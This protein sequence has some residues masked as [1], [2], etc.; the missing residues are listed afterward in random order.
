MTFNIK[1]D[2]VFTMNSKVYRQ[3]ITDL[4]KSLNLPN[5]LIINEEGECSLLSQ[6]RERLWVKISHLPHFNRVRIECALSHA[7]PSDLRGLQNLMNK[8]VFDLLKPKDKVGKLIAEANAQTLSY[9]A[10]FEL[11]ESKT[12]TLSQAFS[13]FLIEAKDWKKK[14]S[15]ALKDPTKKLSEKEE[16]ILNFN[17]QIS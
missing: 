8:L 14:I 12:N 15:S 1:L 9:V 10:E 6:D 7:L 4:E 2:I 16:E 3:N 11:D 5:S 13:L 17:F